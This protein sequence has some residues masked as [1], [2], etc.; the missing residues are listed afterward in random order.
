MVASPRRGCPHRTAPAEIPIGVD[1]EGD[2][3]LTGARDR[4]GKTTTYSPSG[5][6]YT[7]FTPAGAGGAPTRSPSTRAPEQPSR[8]DDALGGDLAAEHADNW[9]TSTF[10]RREIGERCDARRRQDPAVRAEHRY[11]RRPIGAVLPRRTD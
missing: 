10:A 8:D 2:E 5:I 1:P 9:K 4:F 7:R 11:R 6:G 3:A